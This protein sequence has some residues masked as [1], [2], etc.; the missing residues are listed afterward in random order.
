M[1]TF[2]LEIEYEGTRYSG[3]QVQP[4]ARTVQ[5]ELLRCL[6]DELKLDDFDFQGAGRTDAGVHALVQTAHLHIKTGKQGSPW[7]RRP[8]I[9]KQQLNDSLPADINILRVR[10]APTSF[11]ARHSAVSRS[12]IYQISQRRTAFGKRFVWWI[13]DRLDVSLME[14]AAAHLVGLHDFRSFSASTSPPKLHVPTASTARGRTAGN[15]PHGGNLTRGKGSRPPADGSRGGPEQREPDRAETR[16]RV[17]E[18]RVARVGDL[19]LLRFRAS[20]FLWK[21]VRQ[22][23]GVLAE[24]GRKQ[25]SPQTVQGWLTCPSSEPA[26]LTCP[27]SGLFLERAT[28]PGEEG[29]RPDDLRPVLSVDRWG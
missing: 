25:L 26:R 13:K 17:E 11:H 29:E 16:V 19:I 12:Y 20:H 22:L 4:N 18:I 7:D 14:D 23:V 2:R 27:P 21:M 6:R 3:W 28:Y 15:Q 10:P 9:L 5:G 1:S 8:D 24:V